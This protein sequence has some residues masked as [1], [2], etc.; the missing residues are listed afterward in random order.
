M[1]RLQTLDTELFRF[2]NLRL[3]NPVFDAVMPFVSGNVFFR[4]LLLLAGIL[5]IWKGRVRGVVCALMLVLL[6]P[7]GDGLIYNTIKHA[8][9]RPRPFVVMPDVHRPGRNPD[10][11]S[12]SPSAT[13]AGEKSGQPSDAKGDYTSMPSSHAANWFA[14]MMI[15]FIY[16]RRSLWFLLPGAILV[17]FSRIYNGVHYPSDVTAGAILGAGYAA[18]SVWS[19]ASLWGWAG[20]QWF[21][22]WWRKFPSLLNPTLRTDQGEEEESPVSSGSPHSTLDQHWLRLGYVLLAVLLLARLAYIRSAIIELSRDEAYQWLWS[23]HLALSY[24]SKPPLIAYTQFLGTFLW[25]D[26]AFGV[27]F[28]SPVIG[29][30]LGLL[31]LRFFAREV[32]ARAGFFLLLIITATPLTSVGAVLMTVDPLSVLFWTAA[33]LAGWRAVQEHGTTRQWVWVGLWM[34][35]GFLSKYTALFQLLC[36]AVFFALWPAARKHLRRPGPYVA[37]LLNLICALPV[38]I[39]NWQHH[40]ITVTHVAGNAGLESAWKP[41]LRYLGEFVGAEAGLLNPIFFVATV[42]AAIAFWRRGRYDP[43]QVYLFSMGAPLFLSYLL[44]SFRSR[45]LPNWIAPSVLPLSCL[46]VIYWDARWRLGT[47]RIKP[48]LVSGLVLGLVAVLLCHDTNLITKLTGARL[49]VNQDPLH[50]VRGWSDVARAA[51]GARRA[52]LAEGKPVFIIG[53]H[54]SMVGEIA[55]YLPEAKA[56]VTGDPL[57][58]YRSDSRAVNQFHFWPGYEDRKGQNAIFVRELDR[59]LPRPG[60]VPRE[61]AQQFESV[62]EMGITNVLYHRRILWPIQIFACRGLR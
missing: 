32:N 12:M 7:L 45:I 34:G 35:L 19:L 26:T 9:G 8:V 13:S 39:W 22:R 29:A 28:F 15:L 17:S 27:R 30:L 33:M 25:G 55:F 6:L 18:A 38:L 14:A 43:R 41:T 57:I 50:R 1:D 5:L 16:Y 40:W 49:P 10:S 31:V 59:D 56:T 60:P 24:Y 58:F 61:V 47:T 44:Y 21:P 48:W 2:I 42:W 52:L 20:Q 46:M 3:I 11:A 23:K 54:Y 62:T 51:G 37:L 4:P 53:D 36:W